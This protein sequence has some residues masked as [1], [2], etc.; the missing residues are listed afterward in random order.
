MAVLRSREW[1]ENGLAKDFSCKISIKNGI[2][3]KS[4]CE[5]CTFRRFEFCN[6][7][8]ATTTSIMLNYQFSTGLVASHLFYSHKLVYFLIPSLTEESTQCH[9]LALKLPR[10][11]FK[12]LKHHDSL[13]KGLGTLSSVSCLQ[14]QA[15]SMSYKKF[16]GQHP[17]GFEP[18][19][20]RDL[21][22]RRL[23]YCCAT[24]AAP[25]F[26]GF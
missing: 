13:E 24:T 21:F 4:S 10:F 16:F 11:L 14:L 9:G 25:S 6:V 12:C 7:F 15:C 5:L 20:S 26:W 2:A 18:T 1:E 17:A 8:L 19:T 23:L 22:C 3:Q